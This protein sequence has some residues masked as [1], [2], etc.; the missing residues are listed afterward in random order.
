MGW[1]SS[2]III[3]NKENFADESEILNAI[4]KS[5]YEFDRELTLDECIYPNDKSINIGYYNGNIIISD[6]YQLT[7]NSLERADKLN[8]T[9][10]EKKLTKKF[11]AKL[12]R[13]PVKGGHTYVIWP[14]STSF[15]GTKG[16]VKVKGTVN[17]IPFQSSFMALGDGNHKLPVKAEI[18][19]VIGKDEGDEII[20]HL[21]ER[22]N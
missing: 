1:K 22:L 5:E 19:K 21:T 12:Q 11:K 18:R 7:T 15:F 17:D 6:N 9:R 8:L 16:L 4:G 10:E 3:E 20:V 2:L 13:S 14:E